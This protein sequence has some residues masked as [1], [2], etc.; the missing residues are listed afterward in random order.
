MQGCSRDKLESILDPNTSADCECRDVVCLVET[1]DSLDHF[2]SCEDSDVFECRRKISANG[3]YCGG[4]LVLVRKG[5]F[6]LY[7]TLES[8]S[9]NIL[10]LILSVKNVNPVVYIAYLTP[11]NSSYG[12]EDA[13]ID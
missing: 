12:R 9:E 7:C 8:E 4:V 1:W 3:R 10:W 5:V 6:N 2:S 13:G 11:N